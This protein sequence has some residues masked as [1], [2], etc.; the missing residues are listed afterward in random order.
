MQRTRLLNS[1][2]VTLFVAYPAAAERPDGRFEH[3]DADGDGTITR[4]E[5][6]AQNHAFER[7]DRNADGVL[8]DAD[9][10]AGLRSHH[11]GGPIALAD[12]D[13][14]KSVTLDEW[15]TFVQGLDTDQSGTIDDSERRAMRPEGLHRV[16]G[17]GPFERGLQGEQ[18]VEE[19]TGL[20]QRLDRN[21]DGI[22]NAEDR[23]NR[24]HRGPRGP[25]RHMRGNARPG[26]RLI[27]AADAAGNGD[28]AITREE[29]QAFLVVADGDSDGALSMTEVLAATRANHSESP[30]GRSLPV[31]D[32]ETRFDELDA[33]GDG[34]VQES[35]LPHR[36][37][38]RGHH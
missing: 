25:K 21:D 11:R 7:L 32:L 9:L 14:D 31:A 30:A 15:T 8:N 23:Q 4:E 28:G 2:L 13:Q 17:R 26:L 33:N 20:F 5:F 37:H 27:H 1:L 18:T 24:R 19:M 38:R 36:S 34:T 3:L 6:E 22:V 10:P 29:W 16:R 35:E 12:S